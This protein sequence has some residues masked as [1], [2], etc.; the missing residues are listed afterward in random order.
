M[1][2]TYRDNIHPSP[3]LQLL[4]VPQYISLATSFMYFSLVITQSPICCSY[5]HRCGVIHRGM[6]N[7][8]EATPQ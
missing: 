7:V 6:R 4:L 8:P 5:A 1:D 2:K 3:F